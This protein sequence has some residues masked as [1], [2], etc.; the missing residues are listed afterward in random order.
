ME[1]E[2]TRIFIKVVQQGS[3]SKAANLL[4]MP[5]SNVSRAVSYL[6]AE[7]GTT[8]LQRTTRTLRLTSAGQAF[9]E[10]SVG[11]IQILE[12]AKR[13]LQ[14]TDSIIAGSVK[15]TAPED[16]GEFAVSP[17]LAKLMKK[18]PSLSFDFNYTDEIVDLV[19]EG[20]D[21]AVRLGRLN[22]SRFKAIKVGEVS[23]IAVA[24]PTYLSSRAQIRSSKDL[25]QNDLL[26][27]AG[28]IPSSHRPKAAGNQMRSLVTLARLGAGIALVPQFTCRQEIEQGKLVRVLPTWTSS[29]FTVSLVSATTSQM[30][31]RVRIVTDELV[32]S[33][34]EALR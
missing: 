17:A 15:L 29:R 31:A 32:N 13:S 19:S 11:P 33:L 10:A 16:L 4:K 21:L 30:P 2:T 14:G 23:I 22:P 3:F 1:L 6:E 8:L 18:H 5:V 7:V 12:D 24:S 25:V 20:Y 26:Y 9:F 27:F 34:K 28:T